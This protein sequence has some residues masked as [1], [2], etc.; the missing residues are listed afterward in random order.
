M[1][2]GLFGRQGNRAGDKTDCAGDKTDKTPWWAALAQQVQPRTCDT[3]R[4][5]RPGIVKKKQE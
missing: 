3:N 2:G 5:V 4:L 1:P